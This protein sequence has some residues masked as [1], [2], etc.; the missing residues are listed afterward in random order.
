M[1][2]TTRIFRSM[3]GVL[4]LLLATPLLAQVAVVVTPKGD[5]ETARNQYTSGYSAT[6][7]V[8]NETPGGGTTQFQITCNTHGPVVCDSIRPTT[9]TLNNGSGFANVTAYYGVG[10]AGI[11]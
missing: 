10:T 1:P 6:F 11:G 8:T 9:L 5:T 2:S 7:R 3:L 4:S